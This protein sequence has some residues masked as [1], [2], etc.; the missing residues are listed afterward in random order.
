MRPLLKL[1]EE[2][3]PYSDDILRAMKGVESGAVLLL[4]RSYI[5]VAVLPEVLLLFILAI[6]LAALLIGA[7]FAVH[8]LISVVRKPR[9]RLF[10]SF[11]HEREP[12]ADALAEEMTKCGM[13]AKKLPFV[14]SPD[15]DTLLDQVKQEIRDC[16]VFI[17]VPGNRPSFV[18]HEVSMAFM[19]E[20]PL[21]FVLIEADAPHL[22]D[23]A[24]KGY[25]VFAL[26]ELQRE[27]FRTLANF[28]SYLTADWRSTVRLYGAVFHHLKACAQLVVAV[29]I[30]SLVI[31][32]NLF[33][34]PSPFVGLATSGPL[35]ELI[36]I[37]S[38]ALRDQLEETRK[39]IYQGHITI[40]AVSNP[41]ILLFL[42]PPL[43]LFLVPYGLFF[44]TRWAKRARL[45]SV[46]SGKKFR[47]T[48]IPETLAYSLTRTD[49]LKIFYHGEIVAH[50]ESGRPART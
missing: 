27:G 19:D 29:Y 42:G 3:L 35:E 31:L 38:D 36:T 37:V 33:E 22:P 17:C 7:V 5:K 8:L 1:I 24:K 28:C 11:Q 47:D 40:D 20:K 39:L 15:S 18:E 46:I 9:T 49:L 30:V 23:T 44:I 32:T 41:G 34:R 21:L 6:V 13:R 14:E 10:I 25:P 48:F 45:R 2:L 12:I 16:H 26:G 43:M 50:H 4:L